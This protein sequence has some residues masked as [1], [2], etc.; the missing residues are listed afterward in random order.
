MTAGY[1]GAPVFW[2]IKFLLLN[3][4]MAYLLL[5]FLWC[6]TGDSAAVI[7]FVHVTGKYLKLSLCLQDFFWLSIIHLII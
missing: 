5:W 6:D 2:M 4:N 7:V 3:S 1:K